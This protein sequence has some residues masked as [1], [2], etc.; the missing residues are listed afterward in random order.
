MIKEIYSRDIDSPKYNNDVIVVTDQLQQLI[1]K[2]ENCLFTRKGDV[3][4][5]P[6]M[7]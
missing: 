5:A 4:G 7:G 6:N 1:L 2:V 3:L